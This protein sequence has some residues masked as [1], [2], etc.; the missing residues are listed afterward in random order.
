MDVRFAMDMISRR[1]LISTTGEVGAAAVGHT[2]TWEVE[3]LP[4][5]C[6]F[7]LVKKVPNERTSQDGVSATNV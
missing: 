1:V 7:I 3:G 5:L 6:R 2:A 4:A